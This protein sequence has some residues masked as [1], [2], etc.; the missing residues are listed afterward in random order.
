M[1]E[2]F[3]D[4]LEGSIGYLATALV[5][6]VYVATG[7][8]VPG[9]NDRSLLD[10]V[11][12][13]VVGFALGVALNF[14]LNLQGILK[15]KRAKKMLDTIKAHGEAVLAIEPYIHR[16]DDWCARENAKAL[17][18]ERVRLLTAV[19]MR[20]D[21]CFD[22]EGMPKEVDLSRYPEDVRRK[23]R[24][25]LDTATRLQLTPLSAASLTGEGGRPGD[26][27]YFGETVDEYQARSNLKDAL[28]KLVIAAGFGYFSVDM[29][30]NFDAAA[31]IWRMLY[32]AILLALGIAKLLRAYLFITDTYR[33]NIIKRINYLQSFKN[34]AFETTEREETHGSK[35]DDL[36]A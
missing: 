21:D 29:V 23:R 31:L 24:A 10:I 13:G 25:A 7:L 14:C 30:L 6:I 12:E 20:Y 4:W 9:I 8:L 33:G 22:E 32:V 15:G 17:R 11:R 3:K 18:R 26:P 1:N 35:H 16:L 34:W 28:S 27:F 5:V 36:H 2:R 19:A